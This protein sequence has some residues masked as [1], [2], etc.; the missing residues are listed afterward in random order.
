MNNL[1]T[2]TNALLKNGGFE[3]AVCGGFAIELFLDKS[4]R[5]HGDIDISAFWHDRDKIILYMRSLDFDIYEPCGNRICHHIT[6]VSNQV[7]AKRNLFCIK[8]DSNF[9]VFFPQDEK[10]MCRIEFDGN[11]QTK[12]DFVEIIFNDTNGGNFLYAR[13]NEISLPL[14]KAIMNRNGIPYLAPELVLL[15]KSTDIEREGYQ[16]DYDAAMQKMNTGQKNWLKK[17][18]QKMYP[19]GHEW[20][21]EIG[22]KRGTVKLSEHNPNWVILA[23]EK[24]KQL[25]ECFGS[26]AKDIQHIGSTAIHHIKAKPIIDIAVG[27]ENFKNLDNLLP[28]LETIAVCKSAGQ[29]FPNI[30]LFSVDDENG[31]RTHNIQV[32][33]LNS[34]EWQNHIRFRDYLNLNPQIASDYEKLKIDLASQCS[35]DIMAYSNGKKSFIEKCLEKK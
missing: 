35:N 21:K 25:W 8:P 30:V 32:V 29:P 33:I 5:K 26:T 13:N 31:L 17:A 10:D 28:N 2:E 16:A 12:S 27:V 20:L 9:A 22:L 1:V 23:A 24:I 19:S 18:L 11:G 15:Y 6:D 4:I 34:I 3:Y 14:D 7:K